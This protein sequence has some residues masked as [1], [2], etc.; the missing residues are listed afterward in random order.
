MG[1]ESKST[2]KLELITKMVNQMPADKLVKL[3]T[4]SVDWQEV[5]FMNPLI[6]P[7]VK[8]EFFP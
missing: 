3:K 1:I 6:V 4:F 2:D 5:G 7:N 8:L